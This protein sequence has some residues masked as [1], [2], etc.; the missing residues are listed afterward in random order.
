[1][2]GGFWEGWVRKQ[3]ERKPVIPCYKRDMSNNCCKDC[4]FL[5]KGRSLGGLTYDINNVQSLC[6]SCHI[7]KT[8]RENRKDPEREAW[9]GYVAGLR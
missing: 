9:R 6:R 1:M 7:D 3:R 8:A 5:A 4:H 2:E